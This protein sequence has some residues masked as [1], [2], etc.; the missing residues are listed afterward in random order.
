[1]MRIKS[2]YDRKRRH[3]FRELVMYVCS[4]ERGVG[5]KEIVWINVASI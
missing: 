3:R 4:K 5:L 2:G 1:M